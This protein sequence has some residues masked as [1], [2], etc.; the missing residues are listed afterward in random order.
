MK[1]DPAT[2]HKTMSAIRGKNTGIEKKLRK[3]LTEKGVRYRLYSSRVFGHPDILIAKL[4]I[5]IFCDSEFWHGYHFEENLAA[6]P[7]LTAFWIEK[8]RRNIRRDKL[9]NETLKK[10]GYTVL[11]YW[12]K[13]IEKE[14]DEVVTEILG[15]IARREQIEAW[16]SQISSRTTLAYIEK[17]DSY[18]LLHRVKKDHDVNQG[19]WIGIGGHLEGAETPVQAMKREIGEETGLTVTG[20]RYYGYIDFLNDQAAPERMYLYKVTSFEGG[21]IDCDEG[22]LAWVKKEKMRDLPMWEGDKAFLPLL[23]EEAESPMR[24]TLIYHANELDHVEGPFYPKKA[25]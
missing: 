9:V 22:E 13:Q 18:L 5:A 24:L 25:K 11:R 17:G 14:I 1:R 16:R 20:Y 6:S 4:K 12:G 21:L 19:K 3:A 7:N 23:E 2:I 8:I 10:Q 15:V